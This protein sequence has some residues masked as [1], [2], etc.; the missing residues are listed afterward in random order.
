MSKLV[1]NIL[2][3]A[4]ELIRDP[5]KWSQGALARNKDGV[6]VHSDDKSA[7]SWCALGAVDFIGTKRREYIAT[8]RALDAMSLAAEDWAHT[9]SGTLG[10]TAPTW[11]NDYFGHAAV[12]E[13]F[14]RAIQI[15]KEED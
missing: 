9:A 1:V 3:E 11:V 2:S 6:A 14:D 4:Q 12:M 10:E 15:A 13:M 7:C 5:S 8:S